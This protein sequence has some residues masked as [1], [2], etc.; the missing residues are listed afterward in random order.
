MKI[1]PIIVAGVLCLGGAAV[2]NAH[3]LGLGAAGGG[4]AIAVNSAL[5][6]CATLTFAGSGTF[7]GQFTA[8]GEM[9]GPGTKVGSIRGAMPILVTSGS[10]W[11]GCIPGAYSGATAGEAK[12]TLS[13][14]GSVGDYVEVR[15]CAIRAGALTCV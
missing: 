14:D 2:P 11:H 1:R 5:G 12:F 13:G 6:A 8:V 7:V 9:Q 15:Q 10:T 3:A 4:G